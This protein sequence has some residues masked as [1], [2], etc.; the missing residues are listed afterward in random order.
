MPPN[1]GGG[2]KNHLTLMAIAVETQKG[3]HKC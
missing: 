3:F 1:F 2:Y